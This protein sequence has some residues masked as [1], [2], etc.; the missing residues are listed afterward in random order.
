MYQ[1]LWQYVTTEKSMYTSLYKPLDSHW[2]QERGGRS[3]YWL[4]NH[5][6]LFQIRHAF[7]LDSHCLHILNEPFQPKSRISSFS[8]FKSKKVL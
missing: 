3:K 2:D 6:L 5:S 7:S 8:I 4:L 1:C